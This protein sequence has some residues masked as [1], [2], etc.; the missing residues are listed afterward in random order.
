MKQL[1][2]KHWQDPALAAIGAWLALSPWALGWQDDPGVMA[3]G[4][5]LGLTLVAT[6]IGAILVPRA[7]QRWT[8]A[9]LGAAA[10]ASPWLL[11]FSHLRE[12]TLNAVAAGFAA[13]VLAF[14]V[15]AT[16]CE[17]GGGWWTDRMAH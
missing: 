5:A 15:L 12:P 2:I 7:W 3:A 10:V 1:H 4:L 17:G 9:A 11:A 13:I 6:A 8:A 14:W 16:D